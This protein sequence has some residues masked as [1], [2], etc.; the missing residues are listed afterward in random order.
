LRRI[1]PFLLIVRANVRRH[2]A[3]PRDRVT[4]ATDLQYRLAEI[5]K[6]RGRICVDGGTTIV[7]ACRLM[8]SFQVEEYWS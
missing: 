4:S 8:R 3:V 6:K 2:R 7:T 5:G 1:V